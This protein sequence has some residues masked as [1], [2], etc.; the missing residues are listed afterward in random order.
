MKVIKTCSGSANAPSIDPVA[1]EVWQT[2]VA[3][4]GAL[5]FPASER[6]CLEWAN[7]LRRRK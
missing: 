3:K 6:L 5:R 2:F 7:F 4:I 1:R